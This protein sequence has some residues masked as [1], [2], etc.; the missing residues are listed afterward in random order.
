MPR[1]A[2]S[3]ATVGEGRVVQGAAHVAPAPATGVGPPE[4]PLTRRP[5]EDL[6]S[7]ERTAVAAASVA[8][9]IAGEVG[10]S[11]VIAGAGPAGPLRVLAARIVGVRAAVAGPPEVP[12]PGRAP[13]PGLVAADAAPV[14]AALVVEEGAGAAVAGLVLAEGPTGLEV[15]PAR[16]VVAQ[17][18]VP[19]LLPAGLVGLRAVLDRA[20]AP[21]ASTTAA[22]VAVE[23]RP[24]G[25][26]AAR[27]PL[28]AGGAPASL[29]AI[30]RYGAIS[31][32]PRQKAQSLLCTVV[33]CVG[34]VRISRPCIGFRKGCRFFSASGNCYSW[35]GSLGRSRS[36]SSR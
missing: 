35:T 13:A 36:R 12:L 9:R 10:P 28:G 15:A 22:K 24:A 7:V 11:A 31:G 1:E 5:V 27:R 30:H 32:K 17:A 20:G 14:R 25:G 4:E 2:P 33:E 23:A 19:T 3:R 18:L 29:P 34:R 6:P 26:P 16:H 8:V 21:V